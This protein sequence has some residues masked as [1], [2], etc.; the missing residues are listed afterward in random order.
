MEKLF[1]YDAASVSTDTLLIMKRKGYTCKALTKDPGF[2]WQSIFELEED[3]VFVLLSHGDNNGPMMVEGSDNAKCKN[4][5]LK[6]FSEI[7]NEKR[8]KL[9][10]LSCH[11][12]VH[13][14]E[15]ILRENNVSFVA[16]KGMAVFGTVN[17]EVINVLS[18]D[19]NTYPGWVGPLC[20]NRASKAL[21]LP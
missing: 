12:G 16:P 11:T 20:P 3:G 8:L 14:C 19:G 17:Q 2:F 1:L 5:D 7:L 9:Y 18:K 10:L 15:T 4:I 13:P 21:Y 6:K